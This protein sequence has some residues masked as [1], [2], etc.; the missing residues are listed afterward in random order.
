MIIATFHER[1]GRKLL[2]LCDK[3]LLGK[4]FEEGD[5]QLDLTAK[6]YQ[7]KETSIEELKKDIA[8]Y[9]IINAVGKESVD[10]LLKEELITEQGIIKI[11]GISHAQCVNILSD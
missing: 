1:N 6:F 5:L 11:A 7:G 10:L 4:K 8:G 2:A 3:D 9:D